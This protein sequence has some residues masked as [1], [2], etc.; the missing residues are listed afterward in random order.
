MGTNHDDRSFAV[1]QSTDIGSGTKIWQFVVILGGAKIGRDC[2]ICAHVFIENDVTVGDRVTVKSGVQLWDGIDIADDVFIGPNATF[3]NDRFPRSRI[4]RQAS[5]RTVV[6]KGASIGAAAT[7]LP[8]VSI[9]ELAIVGAGA[10]V[11]RS[12]PARAIVIGNPARIAG[13][14]D[15]RNIYQSLRKPAQAYHLKDSPSESAQLVE[16]IEGVYLFQLN[17][18]EDI[19]GSLTPIEFRKDLPFVPVRLFFAYGVPTVETR[20]EHAHKTCHQ[21]LIASSGSISVSVDNGDQSATVLLDSPNKALHIKPMIWAAQS[22]FT[23]DACLAVL[24]SEPYQDSDYIR[25]YSDFLESL[26][27]TRKD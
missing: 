24:A 8:G 1:I 20:G 16:I 4:P 9:G 27:I 10:V 25:S 23:S 14:V 18:Y 17:V 11:T 12:V 21:L 15:E 3:T 5:A 26:K 13:Y 7:I 6:S 2:N 22:K 19:R